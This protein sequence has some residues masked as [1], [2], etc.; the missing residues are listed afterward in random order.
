MATWMQ[1]IFPY[2]IFSTDKDLR[3]ESWNLW[4]VRHSGLTPE[5]VIG[6]SIAEVFPSLRERRL[7][8][9]YER[10]AAGEIIVLSTALHKYLLPL[11]STVPESGLPHMLQTARIAPIPEGD[12]IVGTVTIIEDVTQREFQAGIVN[13]QQEVDRLLSN[14][15]VT[16]L[17]SK[18]PIQDMDLIFATVKVALGLDAYAS[19]LLSPD[20]KTLVM[21]SST[22]LAPRDRDSI[23]KVAVSEEEILALGRVSASGNPIPPESNLDL[24]RALAIEGKCSYPLAVGDRVIG[25]V[26][27]ASYARTSIVAADGN[28]L[29]RIASYVAIAID[30]ERRERETIRASKAKD[31]FLAALSHELRTPLN[32]VLLMASDGALNLDY[33]ED[34]RESFAVIER[35]ALLEARLIDDLLDITR[36]SHGKLALDMRRLDVV[37]ALRDALENVRPSMDE[38]GLSVVSQIG[39]TAPIAIGDY[40]RLQQVF[41]NILKN[42]VKFTPRGGSVTVECHV[43]VASRKLCISVADTGIGM[44]P[45]EIGRFF[46]AFSQGDH[47]NYGQAHRFGGLGLGLAISRT[48]VEMHGG[49]ITATSA[50]R[51]QGSRFTIIL[52]CVAEGTLLSDPQLALSPTDAPLDSKP[53]TQAPLAILL[54]EDHETTRRV[55]GELLKRRG[56]VVTVAAN[57]KEAKAAAENAHFDLVLS[58]IGLPD[59]DGFTLMKELS[60]KHGL[61]GVALTGYGMSEDIA[62]SRESGFFAHIT[63]PINVDRLDKIIADEFGRVLK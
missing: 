41:W 22:G 44:Q 21:N 37:A 34:V 13:R 32:P 3:V 39:D 36:I 63:K 47:A 19:Y 51:D 25:L 33:P 42:A 53:G 57:V 10:A 40:G 43:E 48:L 59:G 18:D 5:E 56:H 50:G 62:R 14:A 9:R 58:D 1:E 4:M 31:E 2:G 16:L 6:R 28:T 12:S 35:N 45:H 17:V 55:L 8:E 30:R 24:L 38:K 27:F 7:V 29:S 49:T 54:I 60:A 52:P 23:A 15:L 46:E 61:K 26:A 11:T 20:R